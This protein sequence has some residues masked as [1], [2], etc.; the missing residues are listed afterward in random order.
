MQFDQQR[1]QNLFKQRDF[2]YQQE[3][4]KFGFG[5]VFTGLLGGGAGFLSGLAS[6]GYFNSPAEE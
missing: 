5:D 2:S 4:D 3:Q 1:L 6:G